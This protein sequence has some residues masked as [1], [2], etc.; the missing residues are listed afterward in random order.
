MRI[1]IV[2]DRADDRAKLDA[3]VRRW[4]ELNGV[5]LTPPPALF[6]SGEA[7]MSVFLKDMY[8]VVFLDIYMD[9]I[10]GMDVARNIRKVDRTVRI[11]FI[12]TSTEF[13]VDSYDVDSSYYMVKPYSDEKLAIAFERCGTLLIEKEQ[14][15]WL[16]GAHGKERLVLHNVEYAEYNRRRIC[17]YLMDGGQMTVSMNWNE[18]AEQMLVYPYFCDCMK[19][20]LVNF[21]AVEKL[22]DDSFI[23]KGGA[24]LPISRLKYRSVREKFFDWSFAQARGGA[25]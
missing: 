2:D 5:P 15:I 20:M 3:S 12:T 16:P 8:D 14:S 1:A 7:F 25:V 21:E 22:T 9:G 17:V 23:M 10:T 19:G 13:A 18:F 4:A 24:R 11:I 6:E